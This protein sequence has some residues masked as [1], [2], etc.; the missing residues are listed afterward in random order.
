VLA[1][2]TRHGS[3]VPAV[4]LAGVL[5]LLGGLAVGALLVAARRRLD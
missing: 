4:T 1:G 2:L 5:V 3:S